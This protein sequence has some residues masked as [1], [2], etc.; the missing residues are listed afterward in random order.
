MDVLKSCPAAATI[1][2]RIPPPFF[3]VLS[4]SL[5]WLKEGGGGRDQRRE[6]EGP[7]HGVHCVCVW[8]RE[9]R[10]RRRR[11]QRRRRR[12][13]FELLILFAFNFGPCISKAAASHH[14]LAAAAI[15]KP[16]IKAAARREREKE[17]RGGRQKAEI[18]W[19]GF[20]GE[21]ERGEGV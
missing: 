7:L 4:L 20:Y 13:G 5:S 18:P 14:T 3:D 15:C 10:R 11:R 6:R 19:P 16:Y 17:K 12:N 1:R 9:G 2:G 8:K 21:R